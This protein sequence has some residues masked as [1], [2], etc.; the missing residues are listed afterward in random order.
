M[1][2]HAKP[3]TRRCA[4]CGALFSTGEPGAAWLNRKAN[5]RYIHPGCQQ[6][7][8]DWK[9]AQRSELQS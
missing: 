5:P 9:P 1:T 7:A 6:P 3:Y 2:T 8:K 4:T